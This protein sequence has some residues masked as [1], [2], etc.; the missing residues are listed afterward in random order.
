VSSNIEFIRRINGL[1][2]ID[3]VHRIVFGASYLVL[4]LGDVYLGAPV[5]TPVDPRHRLVTTKYNPAERGHPRTPWESAALTSACTHG[6]PGRLSIRRPHRPDVE[7]FS[8]NEGVSAGTPWLLRFFDQV[9]FFPV[10]AAELLEIRDAFPQGKYSLRIEPTEFRLRDYHAFLKSINGDAAEFK[11]RQQQAFEAERERWSA[12]GQIGH[13]EPPDAFSASHSDLDTLRLQ[14]RAFPNWRK[15]LDNC[16]GNGT[17]GGSRAETA[18]AR[19]DENG[20][21]RCGSE[22]RYCGKAA[23]CARIAGLLG[24]GITGASPG[25]HSMKISEKVKAVYDRLEAA[26]LSPVWI[27]LVPRESALARARERELEDS[28]RRPFTGMTFAVKDNIDVAGMPTTAGCPAYAYTLLQARPCPTARRCRRHPDR[29]DEHGSICYRIG[30]DALAVRRLLQRVRRALHFRGSSS[31]S[32]VA[33]AKGL[34][35]FSLGTDT[36]GSGRVPAAFNNLIGLKPTRGLL[37][38]AGVVPACR[39]LDCVSI[40]AS[41]CGVA[42]M[43]WRAAKVLI[44]RIRIPVRLGLVKMPRPGR[45]LLSGSCSSA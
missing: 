15:R 16:R 34:V 10:S 5:A 29:Q 28:L 24:T 43:V 12:A 3:E 35:T 30:R 36:A 31:G 1:D 2:S 18:S 13:V 45:M 44:P 23:L 25:G 4:G 20:D 22:R 21:R 9:R 42:H 33:V 39:T 14:A 37:S 26:P 6:R 7:H 38:T 32:A 27:S 41:T 19:S 17:K 8:I 40:L 11:A